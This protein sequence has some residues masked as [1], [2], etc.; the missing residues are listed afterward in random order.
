[1]QVAQMGSLLGKRAPRH[2]TGEPN[3]LLHTVPPK[4]I[5]NLRNKLIFDSLGKTCQFFS[6]LSSRMPVYGGGGG[7]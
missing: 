6:L 5:A 1:M 7:N 3:V 2:M 4:H